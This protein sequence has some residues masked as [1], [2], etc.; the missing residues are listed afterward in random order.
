MSK[1][2]FLRWCFRHSIAPTAVVVLAFIGSFTHAKTFNMCGILG[3]RSEVPG[4]WSLTKFH[5]SYPIHSI[6]SYLILSHPIPSYPIPPHPQLSLHP[7]KVDFWLWEKQFCPLATTQPFAINGLSLYLCHYY[8][9]V[10]H[11]SPSFKSGSSPPHCEYFLF[12]FYCSYLSGASV[13]GK[14][15][16]RPLNPL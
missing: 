13:I 15:T 9:D 8:D 1:G 14:M 6:P 12:R 3:R 7:N 11:Y 4:F 5:P 16:T 10:W 2:V